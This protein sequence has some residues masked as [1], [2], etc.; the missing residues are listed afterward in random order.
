MP[1]PN[2]LPGRKVQSRRGS[3]RNRSATMVSHN[4]MMATTWGRT[5]SKREQYEK[6]TFTFV[7]RVL[8]SQRLQL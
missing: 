4:G 1:P 3:V 5:L 7:P 6:A 8:L 2:Y